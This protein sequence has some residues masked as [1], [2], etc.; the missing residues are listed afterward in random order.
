MRKCVELSRTNADY[1]ISPVEYGLGVS[2]SSSVSFLRQHNYLSSIAIFSSRGPVTADGSNRIKPEIIA[3]GMDVL[4]SFPRNT[5]AIE[6]GTSMAGPHVVGV[7]ALLW[8]AQPKLIGNIERTAQI[9][10]QTAKPYRG[11]A[12]SSGGIFPICA[13]DHVPSNVTG[14]GVVDAYA[15]V[16]MALGQK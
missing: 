1:A 12:Q 4:S 15:A 8:S 14:Y 3:P 2:A 16:Q 5:Y 9:L 7:V 6:S 10:T 11:A 13:D